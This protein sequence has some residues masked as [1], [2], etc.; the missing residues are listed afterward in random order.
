MYLNIYYKSGKNLRVFKYGPIDNYDE[1]EHAI[2][3]VGH[4]ATNTKDKRTSAI[5]A[6]IPNIKGEVFEAA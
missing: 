6:V 4:H 3:Q 1:I 2:S 5:L